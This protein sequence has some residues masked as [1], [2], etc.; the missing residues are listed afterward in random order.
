LQTYDVNHFNLAKTSLK[1]TKNNCS[2]LRKFLS[3]EAFA[4]LEVRPLGHDGSVL[5]NVVAKALL[6]TVVC[7]FLS[8]SSSSSDA[9]DGCQWDAQASEYWIPY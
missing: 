8:L 5:L 2:R 1:V 7:M 3:L 4:F 9:V 6:L